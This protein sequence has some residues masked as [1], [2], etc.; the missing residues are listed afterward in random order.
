MAKLV[1][2]M[3][4]HIAIHRPFNAIGVELMAFIHKAK[5]IKPLAMDTF[6]GNGLACLLPRIGN[7]GHQAKAGLIEIAQIN[8]ALSIFFP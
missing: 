6:N 5:N 7:I 1:K 2:T 8:N 4:H 3:D